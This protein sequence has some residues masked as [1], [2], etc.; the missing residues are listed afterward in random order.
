M[1]LELNN[2]LLKLSDLDVYG[3]QPEVCSQVL[4]AY[5]TFLWSEDTFSSKVLKFTL[6][7]PKASRSLCKYLSVCR[8]WAERFG[9]R[10]LGQRV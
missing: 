10:A 8:Y 5:M 3:N 2:P 7:P 1:Y 4:G 6:L 9:M